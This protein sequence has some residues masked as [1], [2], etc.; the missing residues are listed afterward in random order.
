MKIK[1][2]DKKKICLFF[3]HER[4]LRIAQNLKKNSKYKI[5]KIYLSKK[6][7]NVK[8]KSPLRR[9]KYSFLI[10]KN[11]NSKKIVDYN[12]KN[13]IDLNIIC[14]FPYIFN[15]NL[16][17]SAKYGTINL[18]GGKLPDYKGG[19][20]LN[21][22]II[23][24]E[25]KIGFSIIKADHTIDG[26]DILAQSSFRLRENFDIKK[27]HELV[28]K[29]FP[30]L[31]NKVLNQIFKNK[32]NLIKNKHGKTYKQRTPEDGK[33]S[34]NKMTNIEVYNFIRALTKPYPGAF[35]IDRNSGK[36]IFI[37]KSKKSKLNPKIKPGTIFFRN[38]FFH[39]KCAK[40]SIKIL[41]SSKKLINDSIMY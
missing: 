39:I 2:H 11:V 36:K 32:L 18:H 5:S 15:S 31:L 10:I 37:Y 28:N 25:K 30:K 3:N 33:I 23:N 9:L 21:W 26:G 8:I 27:V 22:Q 4:G 17:K 7:L 16:L 19:S 20:P 24:G 13:K 35:C 12:L 34:W 40:G 29:N 38:K 41:K 14:G 6:N 1:D